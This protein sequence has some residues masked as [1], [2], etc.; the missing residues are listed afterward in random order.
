[1]S[2][3]NYIP[4]GYHSVTPSL[5]VR[6]GKAA[7]EFY[8]KAF[9]AQELSAMYGPDGKT[10]MHAEIKIGDSIV[11][12]GGESPEMG[13][14]SPQA[15]NG[16]PVSLYLYVDNCD[17]WFKRAV[18]AGARPTMPPADMFWGDRH[19][20][21]TDPSGHNWGI[22]THQEDVSPAEMDKR[23]KEWMAATAKH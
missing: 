17:A 13:A 12:L 20:K 11:M 1:M 2:N 5:V 9:G 23:V 7:L 18:D 15:L 19:A 14:N 8:K 4:A 16:S 22:L 6:D 21:V 10:L 3:V